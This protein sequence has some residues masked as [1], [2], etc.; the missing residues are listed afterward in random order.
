MVRRDVR[1]QLRNNPAAGR[2]RYS[3]FHRVLR[4]FFSVGTF[5]RFVSGYLAINFVFLVAE[6]ALA[7]LAPG[8]LPRWTSRR[9][10]LR[11]KKNYF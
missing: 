2:S 11:T 4:R 1:E 6:A 8:S 9:A 3:R 5:N 10:R 7:W